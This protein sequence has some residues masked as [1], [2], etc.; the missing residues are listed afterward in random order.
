LPSRTAH[1]ETQND[2]HFQSLSEIKSDAVPGNP[3]WQWQWQYKETFKK[4]PQ[5]PEYLVVNPTNLT[6]IK[7]L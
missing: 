2:F 7:K 4:I 6:V 5:L 1:P 3:W